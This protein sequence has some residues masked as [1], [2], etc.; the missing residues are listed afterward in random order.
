MMSNFLILYSNLL[1]VIDSLNTR[2]CLTKQLFTCHLD[3][4]LSLKAS[5]VMSTSI[6]NHDPLLMKAPFSIMLF[7]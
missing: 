3:R 1:I 5:E 7:H 2:V 4:E 6:M